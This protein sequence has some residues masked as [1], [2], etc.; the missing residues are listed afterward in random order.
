MRNRILRTLL[1]GGSA[2]ALLACAEGETEAE[3]EIE[4]PEMAMT[5][6]QQADAPAEPVM[7]EPAGDEADLPSTLAEATEGESD[8]AMWRVGDED[9]TVYLI[10]TVHLLNDGVDWKTDEFE[11]AFAEADAV[12]LEADVLS[13]EVQAQM[14]Q[15]IPELAM[16][17]QGTTLSSY[18]TEEEQAEINEAIAPLGIQ[19]AQLDPYRPWFAGVNLGVAG[20]MK[21]GGNPQ[22]GLETIIAADAAEAGK[23]MRYFETAEEQLRLLASADDEKQADYIVADIDEF[24]NIEG[25]FSELIGAWYDGDPEQVGEILNESF[26]AFPE[27]ADL[28]LYRRNE[29]WADQLETLIEG[30]EGTYLVAVGAGHL[31]DDNTVQDYLEERGYSAERY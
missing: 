16:N 19:L 18:F 6:T 4:T 25:Y 24:E 22:A 21:A 9:T 13:P 26:E 29:N 14:Q 10:G 20:I 5:E 23:E 11:T 2:F 15:L 31:A 30:E 17:P 8:I 12:Y 27:F 3:T 28:I 7:D 1:V